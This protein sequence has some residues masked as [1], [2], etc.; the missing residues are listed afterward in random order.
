MS[1]ASR[2]VAVCLSLFLAG[3]ACSVPIE[4]QTSSGGGSLVIGL[5]QIGNLDPPRAQGSSALTVL[6]TACDGLLGLD[7][8]TSAPRPA[9]A[10]S[11]SLKEG[12][13]SLTVRLRPEL[14]F[15]DGTAVTAAA[16]REALS[17]VARPATSSPWSELVSKVEGYG[18]VLAGNATH[19]SGIRAVDELNLEVELSEPYSDFVTVL[20]HPALLPV[21]LESLKESPDGRTEPVC[22][23]PYR[24]DKGLDEG[25]LRLTRSTGSVSRNDA[26]LSRGRGAAERILVRSFD[27]P[28]DAYQA[29]RSGTVDMAGI[30]D[31]RLAEAQASG[32][33]YVSGPT[34]E[35]LYLAFD[36]ANPAT[37]DP[38][39]RQALSL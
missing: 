17:R 28:E 11:W 16:V 19:L 12:A 18:E 23:G 33:G 2:T 25:D 29:Y 21:S 9:L 30:P 26:Y 8:E 14:T 20:S 3:A 5:P 1:P 27:S 10:E 32:R 7:P 34:P 13:R 38:R 37:D 35:I 15:H 4:R 36:P 31:S 6:G 24:I 22:A 39:F